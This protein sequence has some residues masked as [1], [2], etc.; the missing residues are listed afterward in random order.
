VIK[1]RSILSFVF[2]AFIAIGCA[3]ADKAGK[4][5]T[6]ELEGWGTI[7]FNDELY[8]RGQKVNGVHWRDGHGRHHIEISRETDS[9]ERTLIHEL[10]HAKG[11][12][13]ETDAEIRDFYNRMAEYGAPQ[14]EE[15]NRVTGKRNRNCGINKKYNYVW[16]PHSAKAE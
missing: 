6:V 7:S 14:R 12:K 13:H 10:E 11:W 4:V 16:K 8:L 9:V 15:R 2:L 5:N 3:I 1:V